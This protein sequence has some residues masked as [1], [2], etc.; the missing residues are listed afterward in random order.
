MPGNEVIGSEEFAQVEDVFNNGGVLF[1]HGFAE[2]RNNCYKV[3]EF[4]NLFAQKMGSP[5]ALAVSSGTAALRVALAAL[6]IK[7]GDEIITQAFTFVAT[8]EAIIEARGI[9]ICTNIDHTLNMDPAD[10][11]KRI[12]KNT[13]A[14]IVV[15]MLGTPAKLPEISQICKDHNLALIEDTAWG[16]GG[17]L[18][19]RKLGTWSDIGTFS[20]DFAK[21]ITT[22][23]GGMLLF[24]D[25]KYFKKAAAYHDH[26]H[27]NNPSV[28]RWVD[29]RSQSGFNYRMM[30]LQAAVGI[31]QLSKLEKII[32]AQRVNKQRLWNKLCIFKELMIREEPKGS[33]E[34]ADALIFSTQSDKMALDIRDELIK[35]CHQTKILPEAI[36]WH[37]AGEWNHM[38]PLISAH[39]GNLK[40][41]LKESEAILKSCVA[42]GI[43]VR[44]LSIESI[45]SIAYCIERVLRG[46]N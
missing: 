38:E 1:R 3:Q 23:E 26:G 37:F 4:E 9:P 20:F 15:H 18:N 32:E 35:K 45:N 17:S 42:I 13:K 29:S 7:A 31:A 30:E 14:V 6:D 41:D 39:K 21:T 27:E 33:Y 11:V 8:V 16:C 44:E 36:S 10:L 34:T 22:G 28:P 46:L 25:E 43:G 2:Q 12:T 5:Y 40:E 24:K 19:S